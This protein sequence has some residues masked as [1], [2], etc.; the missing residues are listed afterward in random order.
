MT[1]ILA[2]DTRVKADNYTL[3]ATFISTA[4]SLFFSGIYYCIHSRQA[5][6]SIATHA[7]SFTFSAQECLPYMT[8]SHWRIQTAVQKGFQLHSPSQV[9][10][11]QCIELSQGMKVEGRLMGDATAVNRRISVAIQDLKPNKFSTASSSERSTAYT[12]RGGTTQSGTDPMSDEKFLGKIHLKEIEIKSYLVKEFKFQ[13][14]NADTT[15]MFIFFYNKEIQ[16]HS[17]YHLKHSDSVCCCFLLYFFLFF[18]IFYHIFCCQ[19]FVTPSMFV[20]AVVILV[21]G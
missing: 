12:P 19:P 16:T 5:K 4:F 8:H 7:F 3:T 17:T 15:C 14:A 2:E 6:E 1:Y 21:I 10:L 9:I 18:F 11:D 20:S 13:R